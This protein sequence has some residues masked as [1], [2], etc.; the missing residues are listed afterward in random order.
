M[1]KNKCEFEWGNIV[2]DPARKV[3]GDKRA[4]E[5]AILRQNKYEILA[6]FHKK[7]AG[8]RKVRIEAQAFKY[9]IAALAT[10]LVAFFVGT[11]GIGWLA[12][13]LAA[14][15]VVLGLIGSYGFGCAYSARR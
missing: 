2:N 7:C 1:N 10:G 14:A 11:G 12:W 8:R 4:A 9:A 13:T 5:E 15:A 6:A 3:E